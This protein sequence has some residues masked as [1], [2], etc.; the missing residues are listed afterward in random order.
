MNALTQD[1][2]AY[3]NELVGIL[4]KMKAQQKAKQQI[5]IKFSDKNM[6]I[7]IG[8]TDKFL[9]APENIIPGRI[10]YLLSR[11]AEVPVNGIAV[12]RDEKEV[13]PL[14]NIVIVLDSLK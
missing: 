13:T 10:N 8:D 11:P 5:K 3:K 2:N 4:D 6:V 9:K 1:V 7:P 12:E 14:K